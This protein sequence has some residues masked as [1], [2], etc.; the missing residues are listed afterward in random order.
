MTIVVINNYK[1]EAKANKALDN[2]TKC[3]GKKPQMTDYKTPN[4]TAA[5]A[6]F[7]PDLAILTGSNFMLT[8]S[9]NRMIFQEEIDFV[10]DT[11]LPILG[12]CFG[13]QLIGL[14]HGSR[15]ADLG[16]TVRGYKD[17]KLLGDDRIFAGLPNVIRVTES[18]RQGLTM[19]PKGFRHI[20]ESTT[21][22]VEAIV[23]ETR[24]M[25]GVQ[26]HPERFEDRHPHGQTI[27]Q[28]F[29]KIAANH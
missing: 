12:I 11:D 1:E 24:P 23:H 14:A 5:I 22:H 29:V 18:H 26:F 6:R 4:L 17:I 13:H 3:T 7:S 28:N 8:K 16:Q 15:I 19:V 25:Y 20:A 2:I 21:S 27:I 10:R 9:D